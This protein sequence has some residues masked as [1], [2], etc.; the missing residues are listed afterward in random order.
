[1][2]GSVHVSCGDTSAPSQVNFFA[3]SPPSEKLG[4]EIERGMG[5]PPLV[6][7]NAPGPAEIIVSINKRKAIMAVV[8]S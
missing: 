2:G 7:S 3:M 6:A 5:F 4:L 8:D 1:V